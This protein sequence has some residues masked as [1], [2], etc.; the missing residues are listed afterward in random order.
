MALLFLLLATRNDRYF[1]FVVL[2]TSANYPFLSFPS[3]V[4]RRWSQLQ[5][6]TFFPRQEPSLGESTSLNLG[7]ISVSWEANFVLTAPSLSKCGQKGKHL[8]KRWNS[9]YV[10]GKVLRPGHHNVDINFIT[11]SLKSCSIRFSG[12]EDLKSETH[13]VKYTG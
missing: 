12:E 5:W 11:A 8:Q 13:D 4:S 9:Q 7:N 6:E 1:Q 2:K 3:H 10:F